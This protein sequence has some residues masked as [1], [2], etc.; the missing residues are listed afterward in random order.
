MDLESKQAIMAHIRSRYPETTLL[1]ATHGLDEIS[2]MAQSVM[3]F[4]G[5]AAFPV[6]EHTG[7]ICQP[8]DLKNL[9]RTLFFGRFVLLEGC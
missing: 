4:P 1:M 2:A 8:P 3:G 5:T 6:S 7:R 9:A